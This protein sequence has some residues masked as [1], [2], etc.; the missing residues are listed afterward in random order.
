MPSFPTPTSTAGP[1]PPC[2]ADADRMFPA[3]E[4]VQAG[5]PTLEERAALA[6]CA[7]CPLMAACRTWALDVRLPYGIAGGLTAADRR[8]GR[9]TASPTASPT[10]RPTS[11]GRAA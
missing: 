11:P 4:S 9:R 10:V 3:V 7:S 2:A 1:R 6:M 5:A 8:A